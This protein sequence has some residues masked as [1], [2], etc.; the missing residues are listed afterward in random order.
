M[1]HE[2][3]HELPV[4]GHIEC[5]IDNNA[6]N[7]EPVIE[8]KGHSIPVHGPERL[9]NCRL[10]G[11]IILITS[12]FY[13][14]IFKQ[15]EQIPELADIDC[16]IWPCM[17]L[18]D[19]STPEK[20]YYS[21]VIEESL[22]IYAGHLHMGKTPPHERDAM[23]EAFKAKI[24]AKSGGLRIIPSAVLLHSNIC[25]LN[26][27]ECCDLI[28]H[29][30]NPYYI[31]PDEAM[32]DLENMLRGVDLCVQVSLTDGEPFLYQ[33]LAELIA[34]VTAHPKVI[35]VHITTNATI[36]PSAPVLRALKHDK[37]SVS[38]SDYGLIEKLGKLVH[39]FEKEGINFDVQ[40]CL[41]WKV[42]GFPKKRD[43]EREWLYYEFLRCCN[44]KFAKPLLQ[45]RLYACMPA[46]RMA[47]IGIFSAEQDYVT[48]NVTDT[49]EEIWR[50]IQYI[51]M[52]GFIEACTWCRFHDESVST[53]V[54]SGQER[55]SY[56][57]IS[58]EKLNY[59]LSHIPGRE[60]GTFI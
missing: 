14:D 29:V 23:F 40:S 60:R 26:C 39:V 42:F 30:K 4:E 45:G 3:V 8:L 24:T 51:T 7:I 6:A 22:R 35:S 17:F 56:T 25:S 50:K 20:K 5:V 48:L 53:V 2:M 9:S 37:M 59:L 57:L 34:M 13:Y 28:P 31:E 36:V 21:R 16:Y 32:R 12:R 33:G 46:F 11:R 54:P 44:R 55:S 19:E 49:D 47:D 43:T 58:K 52:I 15:L 10:D 1:P 27:P 38:I 18:D 41:K